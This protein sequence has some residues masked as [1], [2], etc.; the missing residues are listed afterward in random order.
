[1]VFKVRLWR[2]VF[3]MGATMFAYVGSRTKRERNAR[4]DGI[5]VFKCDSTT[6]QLSLVQLVGDLVNPS[7][8]ARNK[9]A[10]R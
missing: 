5:S 4:G 3:E 9:A 6:G 7:F 8:L 10:N 2:L 1:M